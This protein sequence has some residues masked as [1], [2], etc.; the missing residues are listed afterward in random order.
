MKLIVIAY[1]VCGDDASLYCD[2]NCF[3]IR[4]LK[5]DMQSFIY[6]ITMMFFQSLVYIR[7]CLS[8]IHDVLIQI[9]FSYLII[10]LHLFYFLHLQPAAL[11]PC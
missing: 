2:Y 3:N 11:T 7:V 8:S 1:P 5:L 4:H 10:M 6:S 9:L